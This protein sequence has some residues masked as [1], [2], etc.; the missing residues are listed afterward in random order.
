MGKL[1][2]TDGIRGIANTEL[3]PEL[4]L[5]VGRAAA[6][7]FTRNSGAPRVL[8]GRDTRISGELIQASLSAG[9]M[10]AGASVGICGVLPTPAIAYL[11]TELGADAGAVISASHN[12]V[13]DNGIKFF[14][15]DGFKLSDDREGEIETLVD[16][17]MVRPTGSEVGHSIDVLGA[18]DRYIGHALLST[19]EVALDGIRVVVDCAHGAAYRTSPE[20]LARAGAEVI[21]IN[22]EPTGTNINVDCGSTNPEVVAKIV[23]QYRADVG[24]AHDGDADRVIAVD[25]RGSVVDGDAIIAILAS[26]LKEL[27]RLPGNL[28][29]VTVMANLGLRH[30]LAARGIQIV[31]TAVGDR[32]VIEAMR[33]RGAAIGGEQSGHVIFLDYGTTGDGLV[34]GLRLLARMAS[35][36]KHLSE[37]ASIVER[38]PQVL[39]NVRVANRNGLGGA[40]R[41]WRQVES[42]TKR[43]GEDGR[44]LVRPSGTEPLVRVMVEATDEATA[45]EVASEIAAVVEKELGSAGNGT[46]T[47]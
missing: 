31:E 38:F 27:D 17:E 11:V 39:L 3:T 14:G 47:Y 8:I 26:E 5:R 32:Y 42:A 46:D 36:G 45:S 25:E 35:S 24:L 2:G 7:V 37:L 20:A 29:V 43:L 15:P 33:E 44:V 9:L 18:E 16:A 28:A 22:V 12:P 21:P 30:A 34:T 4:A 6:Q 19:D 1:F 41:V 40:Q 10:S 13:E 23:M